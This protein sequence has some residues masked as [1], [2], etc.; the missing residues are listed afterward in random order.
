V[1]SGRAD[2]T[3]LDLSASCPWTFE[4]LLADPPDLASLPA[5]LNSAASVQDQKVADGDDLGS[6]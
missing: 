2:K 1:R 4:E 6:L 3:S 5:R